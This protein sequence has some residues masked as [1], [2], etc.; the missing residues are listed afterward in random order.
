MLDLARACRL[1]TRFAALVLA[2]AGCVYPSDAPTGIEFSWRFLETEASDGDDARRILTCDGSGVE[3]IAAMVEDIDAPAREG[4]FRFP[5]DDG[6]QTADDLARS[7]SEAFL[8]LDAGDYDVRLLSEHPGADAEVLA[9]RSV[10]VLGRAVTLELWQLSLAPVDWTLTLSSAA[11]CTDFALGLYYADPQGSLGE[12]N[13]DEDGDPMPVLYRQKLASDRGLG[14]ADATT[15]CADQDGG[16]LF[17]GVDRGTYRLEVTVDG[18]A[19]A[20]EVEIGTAGPGAVSTT[21][22]DLAALP[23]G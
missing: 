12:V 5:C 2:L 20:I 10:D 23:C 4:T 15:A 16:H 7:A 13:L 14:V 17:A 21:T 9:D 19:C 8:E 11:G 18:L 3:T 22:V 1:R 6:F